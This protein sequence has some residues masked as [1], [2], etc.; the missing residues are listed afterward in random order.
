[1]IDTTRQYPRSLRTAF[2]LDYRE[3]A[4]GI[5]GP[6]VIRTRTPVWLRAWQ[7]TA[8]PRA[9]VSV[10]LAYRKHHSWAYAARI[11]YG[12]AFQNIPF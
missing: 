8:K 1:M 9:F 7:A 11:A 12:I 5:S 2:P 6:V 4:I 10:W 3:S